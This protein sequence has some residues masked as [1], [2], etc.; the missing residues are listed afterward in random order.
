MTKIKIMSVR[1]EDLPYIEEWSKRNN[2]EVDLSREQL[3]EDNVETVSGSDGLSLSQ[4]LPISEEI[5]K[6]L[7]SFGIKQ[8]AQR[9]AGFDDYDLDL[10]TK[11]NLI[12]SNVP[13]YSPRSIAEFAVTQA[14]NVVRY[15]NRI[16]NKM[17]EYDFRWE[18][19]IL[20]QSV[21]DL[22]VAV[23]GTGRIGSIVAQIF[24]EG[25][26]SEVVAYDPFPNENVAKYVTYKDT[27][28]EAIEEADIVT[29]HIPATKYNHHLFN[30][31]LFSY[32]K[33][34]SVFVNCARGSL[35]DTQ[36][37]ISALDQ[38]RLKGVA[39][40]TYEL[41]VGVLTTDRRGEDLNDELLNSLIQRE[42]IIITPHIAFYTEAAVENLIVDALDAAMDVIN[43]GDTRLRVN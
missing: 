27:L 16:Q 9:S 30:E 20:S 3:T 39:L 8:I 37:L 32:F 17:Q 28:Q 5:Y 31:A 14:V 19:S 43:T 38:G 7:E 6:K 41:E 11:Y 29:V 40:D 26:R 42:D 33:K 24:A 25:Y 23:I 2:I 36:A 4:T 34:G 15:S 10:A 12:I 22:K 18:P 21:S 13:S 1:D 35:V